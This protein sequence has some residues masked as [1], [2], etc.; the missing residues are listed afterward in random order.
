ME[1]GKR[2]TRSDSVPCHEVPNTQYAQIDKSSSCN[3]DFRH[4][5]CDSK[6][7]T[8]RSCIKIVYSEN[9]LKILMEKFE[10]ETRIFQRTRASLKLFRIKVSFIISCIFCIPKLSTLA[11]HL[12]SKI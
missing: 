2:M 4:V 10:I 11:V 6:H 7:V 8:S 12:I 3:D 9:A 5:A 1:I